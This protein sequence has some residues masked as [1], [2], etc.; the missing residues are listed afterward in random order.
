MSIFRCSC[1]NTY[2]PAQ[3]THIL[4]HLK[5][6]QVFSKKNRNE[7]LSLRQKVFSLIRKNP[8]IS[9]IKIFDQLKLENEGTL[10]TYYNDYFRNLKK[11]NLTNPRNIDN[12]KVELSAK[13]A[14]KLFIKEKTPTHLNFLISY[15]NGVFHCK[16]GKIYFQAQEKLIVN[17]IEK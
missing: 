9:L 10:R 17:L 5:N 16:C 7:N 1:G 3:K 11:T 15:E 4:K 14:N 13:S 12:V 2:L 6:C 8:S